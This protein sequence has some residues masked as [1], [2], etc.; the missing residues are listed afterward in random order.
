MV[1]TLE[2]SN[3]NKNKIIKGKREN[4]LER[5]LLKG[6]GKIGNEIVIESNKHCH[7]LP[8]L[9]LPPSLIS[10]LFIFFFSSI[11]F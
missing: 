5:C 3:K 2:C 1:K 7:H 8:I 11:K 4:K 9:N 6:E 10:F